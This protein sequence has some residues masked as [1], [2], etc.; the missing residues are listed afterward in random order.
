MDDGVFTLISAGVALIVASLYLLL[1][2]RFAVVKASA[3]LLIGVA[4]MI[5][6]ISSGGMLL[7]VL[8]VLAIAG[9]IGPFAD[10]VKRAHG[11]AAEDEAPEAPRDAQPE[12]D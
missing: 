3:G 4:L 8:A 1:A 7:W 2:P 12:A 11:S 10:A 5:V 6:A 9:G